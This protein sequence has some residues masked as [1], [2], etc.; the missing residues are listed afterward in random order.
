MMTSL[1]ALQLRDRLTQAEMFRQKRVVHMT[2]VAAWLVGRS[3][4]VVLSPCRDSISGQVDCFSQNKCSLVER[5]LM[6]GCGW[7][8]EPAQNC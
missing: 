7:G 2:A 3:W 6:S 4:S 5:S 8:H 1:V